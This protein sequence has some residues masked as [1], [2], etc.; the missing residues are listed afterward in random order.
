MIELLLLRL[1]DYE[2]LSEVEM[3]VSYLLS[4]QLRGQVHE[5]LYVH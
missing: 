1:G 5:T 4:F 2:T 3:T